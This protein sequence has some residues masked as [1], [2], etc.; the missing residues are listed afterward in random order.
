MR[1]WGILLALGMMQMSLLAGGINITTDA[2]NEPTAG[3]SFKL[4]A[5]GTGIGD[6]DEIQSHFIDLSNVPTGTQFVSFFSQRNGVEA[7]E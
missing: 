1:S 6:Q 4:N 5:I 2:E 3:R 7:G